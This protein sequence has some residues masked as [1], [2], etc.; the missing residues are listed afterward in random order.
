MARGQGIEKGARDFMS[1]FRPTLPRVSS[2]LWFVASGVLSASLLPFSF[3][4]GVLAFV[5]RSLSSFV[6]RVIASQCDVRIAEFVSY[7]HVVA[8]YKRFF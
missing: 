4:H 2:F 5:S 3:S 1:L 8:A 6:L 7:P